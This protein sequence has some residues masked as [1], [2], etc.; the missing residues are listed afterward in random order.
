MAESFE[1]DDGCA[2][3]DVEGSCYL[4]VGRGDLEPPDVAV[5]VAAACSN[6]LEEARQ[7]V[8]KALGRFLVRHEGA[9]ALDPLDHALVFELRQSLPHDRARDAELLAQSVFTRQEIA[10]PQAEAGDVLDDPALQLVIHRRRRLPVD[11]GGLDGRGGVGGQGHCGRF[12]NQ[13]ATPAWRMTF[14]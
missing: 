7:R 5:Y 9:L 10:G 1:H 3:S 13:Y 14:A 12:W 11:I 8:D 4:V 2:G 6:L